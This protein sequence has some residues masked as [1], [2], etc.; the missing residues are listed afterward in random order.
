MKTVLVPGDPF[1]P[2]FIVLVTLTLFW[3]HFM[4]GSERF[5]KKQTRRL[6]SAQN[7]LKR[8]ALSVAY[9][10]VSAFIL[11]GLCPI[12]IVKVLLRD[13]IAHF[14]LSRAQGK[15]HLTYL[16]PVLVLTVLTMLFFSR[17]RKIYSRYPEIRGAR[18]SRFYF[19]MNALTYGMYLYG[20]EC[21]F[22]GFLL[23]GLRE[24]IG[25]LPAAIVS[26]TFVT[27]AHIGTA[28]PV[29]MGSSISGIIFS[30]MALLTGSIWHVFFLHVFIG[31]GMD[32]LCV[33]YR[34][35]VASFSLGVSEES[36]MQTDS[37]RSV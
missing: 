18:V 22:R 11:F 28:F 14:G 33:K 12:I 6:L 34:M 32:Y 19:T 20:Y 25:D 9:K 31:V 36:F 26:M 27:L 15:L 24:P 5:F 29:V 7:A 1:Y 4:F 3:I 8:Q 35:K 37:Q 10:R 13:S 2:F 23:F 30:Y 21:L 16:S 17:R